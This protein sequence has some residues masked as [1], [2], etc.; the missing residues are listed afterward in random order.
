MA[1]LIEGKISCADPQVADHFTKHFV[2]AGWNG[3]VPPDHSSRLLL[4][5]AP[6]HH[7]EPHCIGAQETQWVVLA[8]RYSPQFSLGDESREIS[9]DVGGQVHIFL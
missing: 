8:L 4:G 3:L 2:R 7:F 9:L 1:G 5:Q 6:H